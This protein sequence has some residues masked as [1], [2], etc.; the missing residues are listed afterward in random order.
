MDG[1][2][3]WIDS[4]NTVFLYLSDILFWAV[5]GDTVEHARAIAFAWDTGRLEYPQESSCKVI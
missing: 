5:Q 2:S 3:T 4:T 1:R